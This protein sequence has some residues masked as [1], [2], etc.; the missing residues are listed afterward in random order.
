MSLVALLVVPALI[1]YF[2]TPEERGRAWCRIQA[3]A[4]R[5]VAVAG[6]TRSAGDP[7]YAAL[8]VRRPW[9]IVA[10]ALAA[11]HV[12]VMLGMLFGPEAL[13]SSETLVSWGGNFGPQTTGVERW[14]V[15]TSIFAHRGIVHLLVNV[16]ILL[17]LGLLLERIVG[18]FTFGTIYVASGVLGSVM[19]TVAA[20]MSVFVGASAAVCGLYGLLVIVLFRGIVQ[21]TA[22]RIPLR[23]VTALVPGAAIFALYYW[24][25]GDSWLT[26]KAGLYAG[27]VSGV[28]LTRSVPDERRRLRRFAALGSATAAILMISAMSLQAITDVRPAIADVLAEEERAATEYNAAVKKFTQGFITRQ[29]LARLIDTAILPQVERSSDRFA[30]FANVPD[31]HTALVSEARRYLRLRQDSWRI[32]SD[33]LRTGGMEQLREADERE[34]AALHAFVKLRNAAG[35]Q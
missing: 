4:R 33:A 10:C 1:V 7:F 28:V 31:R 29:A 19:S 11:I 30:G 17:Q 16:A 26:A 22:V 9:P 23:V 5:G 12:G 24:I 27:I 8:K 21:S 32:R 15:F 2:M 35:A 20:P 34:Q 6:P 25:S 13:G 3:L 18:P 14:R